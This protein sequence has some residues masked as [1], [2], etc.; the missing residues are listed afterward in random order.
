MMPHVTVIIPALNEEKAIGLVL[1]DIPPETVDRVIVVDNGS[2]DRTSQIATQSGAQ[3]VHE[4]KRGYGSACLAGIESL[5]P[6]TEIV[7]FMDGDYSDYPE[8]LPKLL[9]PIL[10]GNVEFVLGTRTQNTE[11]LAALTSLQRWGNRLAV[12]LMRCFWGCTYTDLG[13]FRAI[14]RSS[15]EMLSMGDRDFG[16]TIEMQIKAAVLGISTIEVPVRYRA[17]IGS[18]KVSGSFRGAILAGSKILFTI[19]RYAY[20]TRHLDRNGR[21]QPCA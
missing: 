7:V 2:T 15:L 5:S 13:P 20:M 18:S 1:N 6:D 16:W 10:D 3:V 21:R 4:S 9:Q 14:R 17:R 19:F 12:A 8:Q 11:S